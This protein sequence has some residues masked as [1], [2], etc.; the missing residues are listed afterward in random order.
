MICDDFEERSGQF[1]IVS[2]LARELARRI[3]SN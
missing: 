1:A 3:K 2:D